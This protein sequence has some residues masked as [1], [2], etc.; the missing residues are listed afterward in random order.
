VQD[1]P[2]D[3]WVDSAVSL[4][5]GRELWG[6]PKEMA[7]LDLAHEPTFRGTAKVGSTVV[8]SAD[9]RRGVRSVRLPF[10]VV[11]T[12]LQALDGALARTPLRAGGHIHLARSRWEL[13]GP[14]AWLR[15]YRPFLTVAATDFTLRFGPRRRSSRT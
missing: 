14:L 1:S 5:G 8:A 2:T 9:A 13:D 6:I 11:G 3:I 4:A 15:P 12:A 7:D 10:P